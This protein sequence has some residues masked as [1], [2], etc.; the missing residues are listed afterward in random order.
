MIATADEFVATDGQAAT[1]FEGLEGDLVDAPLRQAFEPPVGT[2]AEDDGAT[3]EQRDER[4]LTRI[5]ETP[6]TPDPEA[7]PEQDQ[8]ERDDLVEDNEPDLPEAD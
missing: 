1:D 4:G 5:D 7:T 8:Q 6:S 2:P 3:T